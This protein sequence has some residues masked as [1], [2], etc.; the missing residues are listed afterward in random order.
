MTDAEGVQQ[1]L[2]DYLHKKGINT[3]F[4][5]LVESLLLAKPENPI[6]HIIQYLQA[7]YP[8]EATPRHK[9][10]AGGGKVDNPAATPHLQY[11]SDESESEDEDEGADAVGEITAP[12][13]PPKIMAKGRRTSV[14]AETIDPLRQFERVVHPK[15]AEEREGIGR[16][17]VEN[18]LFKSLDEKQHDIVLDAMFPKEFEPGDIIIKQGDDGDNFY[19]LESGVC[20][21]YKDGEL[22]QTCTEAMSFGE[23]ALMYNSPRA[24]TVKAVQHSKAW[25]LDRQTFK[26]II[27]ETTLKK[28]E[29]HKGFIERVPLLESLSEFERLTVADALKTET[30]SDGE[31]IIAQG[32]DGNLFYI[33]EEGSAVCTKQL[34]PVESPVEMGELT[35]GAYFGEIALLTTRPRQATVTAK[36]KVK[37][38]TLDR[39]TFKRVMGP[40]ENIL[41][42]NI[43]KYNSVIA[44][45][46]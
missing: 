1:E 32:D 30:F 35:S 28:R 34:S 29:A 45:N 5:N 6:V 37:C 21:V 20:E 8:E 9:A 38:L 16:M 36:G 43:D 7:N 42:R 27:M 10:G 19:I 13:P 26:F 11:H 2:Q 40:L 15:S 17:V 12:V 3:L 39:K 44:N 41:K 33:I 24:A 14:S 18:I 46:I 4:I 31:V 25:A 23:L 22:V